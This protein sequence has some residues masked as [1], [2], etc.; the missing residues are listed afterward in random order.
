MLEELQMKVVIDVAKANK[1]EQAEEPEVATQKVME[2]F[3]D[4]FDDETDDESDND[5]QDEGG[6]LTERA[7]AE[8]VDG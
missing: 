6:E 1:I 7:K 5:E 8:E 2:I 3:E 4:L